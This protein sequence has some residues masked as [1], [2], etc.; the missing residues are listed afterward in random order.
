MQCLNN[1]HKKKKKKKYF[2]V[3]TLKNSTEKSLRG[4][5]DT[6]STL[7][8][9]GAGI[10]KKVCMWRGEGGKIVYMGPSLPS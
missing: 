4:K 2:I 9:V 10:S 1:K 3:G 6:S 8:R 5:M 7:S